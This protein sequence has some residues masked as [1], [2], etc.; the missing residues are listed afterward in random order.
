MWT[1]FTI[2]TNNENLT[3]DMLNERMEKYCF[4]FSVPEF[5][6]EDV[7]AFRA[8][9]QYHK[10][11]LNSLKENLARLLEKG[12]EPVHG[13]EYEKKV[14]AALEND[15]IASWIEITGHGDYRV[16]N[17]NVYCNK[18]YKN[19]LFSFCTFDKDWCKLITKEGKPVSKCKVSDWSFTLDEDFY[20]E[21][22][23]DWESDTWKG[24]MFM[25]DEAYAEWKEN[26]PQMVKECT[27]DNSYVYVASCNF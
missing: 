21:L 11:L 14:I 8:D 23:Y 5:L 16:E 20:A 13:V 18:N 6:Y 9:F 17:N 3:R 25:E 27:N 24:K 19:G 4:E 7:S 22:F 2:V 26:Y 10:R 1:E 15:D 12:E